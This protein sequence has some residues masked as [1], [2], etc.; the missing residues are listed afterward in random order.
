MWLWWAVFVIACVWAALHA[1]QMEE[2][3]EKYGR[4][5]LARREF[6][7]PETCRR[8]VT[9]YRVGLTVMAVFGTVQLW[10]SL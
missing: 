7:P 5:G 2:G 4:W 8:V 6:T 9:A 3:V 1:E 10:R